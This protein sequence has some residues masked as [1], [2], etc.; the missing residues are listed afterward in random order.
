MAREHNE[1]VVMSGN[2]HPDL[3]DAICARLGL[4]RAQIT[5]YHAGNRETMLCLPDTV[6]SRNV[7]IVQTATHTNVNDAIMEL[8]FMC[9][10]CRTSAAK[11][12]VG[13]LPYLPYSKQTKL[14]K[15]GAI[16]SKLL[17]KMVSRS[18]FDHI[19]TVDLR[20]KE[21]RPKQ[22]ANLDI[23]SLCYRC[24]VSLIFLWTILEHLRS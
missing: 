13:V 17:A 12:I 4:K 22:L 3:T 24:K 6:R 14:F 18:G 16:A 23:D 9:Y 19:I 8:L 7:Y 15:R 5:L 10:T 20:H 1:I 21:V 2:T 11:K